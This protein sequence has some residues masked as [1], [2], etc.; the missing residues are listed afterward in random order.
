[1]NLK[2]L[3]AGD[4]IP[5]EINVVIEIPSQSNIKYELD[6]E[7]GSLL[8]DRFLHTSCVYPFNYGFIP[9][10]HAEDG[11]PLDVLVLSQYPIVPMSVIK[12][13]P[14]A[15]LNM[16]DEEGKDEKIVAVPVKTVD[17]VFGELSSADD[18]SPATK[19]KIQ[20]FFETYKTLEPEKWVKVQGWSGVEEAKQAIAKACQ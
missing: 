2:D 20:H 18:I 16:E 4:N 12:C 17:P 11:D 15:I 9:S 14:L 13:R 10:S 1:M 19:N 3:P 6:E 7:T 5:E 8:V